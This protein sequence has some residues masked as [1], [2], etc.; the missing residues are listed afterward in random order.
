MSSSEGVEAIDALKRFKH[1]HHL[2][3]N[4]P[5]EEVKIVDAALISGDSEKALEVEVALV[6]DDSPYPE[7]NP[8]LPI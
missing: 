1:Q 7:V 5:T 8:L 3:P 6:E 4:L 2:D